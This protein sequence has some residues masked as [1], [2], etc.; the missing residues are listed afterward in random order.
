MSKIYLSP[1]VWWEPLKIIT[2]EQKNM[3]CVM[4]VCQSSLCP[5]HTNIGNII[6]T[7]YADCTWWN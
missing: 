2:K 7:K 4:S 5:M 3:S 1:P 6:R